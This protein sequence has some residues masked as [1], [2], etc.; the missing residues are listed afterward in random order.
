[1][2]K[3]LDLIVVLGLDVDPTMAAALFDDRAKKFTAG[4]EFLKQQ[5]YQEARTAFEA[6]LQQSPANA[7][8]HFYLGDACQGLKAWA[9]AE[10]HYETSLE[11]DAKSSVAGLAKQRGRK[12]KVWRLLDEGRLAIN[13]VN[14]SPEQIAQAEDTLDV[15]NK[16]GLDDE[17]RAV[18]QQL[19]EKIQQRHKVNHG[20]L[21]SAQHLERSMVL[22]PAGEFIMGSWTGD[23][24]ERPVRR[25]YLDAYF[26]DKD[27]LAVGQYAKFLDAT[28]H[29][30]PPE[31][32]IM[33]RTMHRSRPVVNVDWADAAAYCKWAGKRLPTEAEW[34]KAARGTDGRTYPWGDE[35]PT[36][37]HGNM[38]KE[39]WNNHMGLTPVGMFGDGKSPYGVNDMAGNVWEW[40]NDWYAP[41]YYKTSPLRNPTGPAM[42]EYKVVRGGSW[43][44]GPEGLR[45]SERETHLPSF[46]GYGTGFRCAKTP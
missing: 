3:I 9:C 10:A 27:Q 43:G 16:L 2:R 44:S 8:A 7:L 17:Q 42:S 33:S 14:A 28:S 24:D 21:A 29:G 38:K 18:Y 31:W 26:M 30:A 32:N 20:N 37:F 45:T 25:V 35:P 39:L 23:G 6:G 46:Q 11:L 36:R 12:A 15:A 5:K 4:Y 22:I 1:M 41:D 34:E 19:H 13:Q 40:V